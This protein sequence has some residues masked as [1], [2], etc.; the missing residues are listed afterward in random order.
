MSVF[1][2]G[3]GSCKSLR[4]ILVKGPVNVCSLYW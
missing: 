1:Y 4:P 3:K 2:I